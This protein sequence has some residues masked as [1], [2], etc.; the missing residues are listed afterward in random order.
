MHHRCLSVTETPNLHAPLRSEMTIVLSP[1]SHRA[2]V[3]LIRLFSFTLRLQ[4]LHGSPKT[5]VMW[6]LMI[7]S[8]L[9]S[10]RART[11]AHSGE[12]TPCHLLS[13]KDDSPTDVEPDLP[14]ERGDTGGDSARPVSRECRN[15]RHLA[16]RRR[17]HQQVGLSSRSALAAVASPSRTRERWVLAKEKDD[18]L[19]LRFDHHTRIE[20]GLHDVKGQHSLSEKVAKPNTDDGRLL[21]PRESTRRRRQHA[22]R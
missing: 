11:P 14:R 9:L 5:K 13:G 8:A 3:R 10:R 7:N 21:P 22:P 6:R 16:R 18:P 12:R 4:D 1:L 20:S 17:L 15:R 2:L 19:L